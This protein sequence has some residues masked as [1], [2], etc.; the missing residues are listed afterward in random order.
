MC[1]FSGRLQY[2]HWQNCHNVMVNT[3]LLQGTVLSLRFRP[4]GYRESQTI[5]GK[6]LVVVAEIL[7]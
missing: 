2:H 6:C 5:F 3:Q 4:L 7:G 1:I